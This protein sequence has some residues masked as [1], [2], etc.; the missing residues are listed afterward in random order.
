MLIRADARRLPL[1]DESVQCV[2]TSPPYWGLRDYDVAGQIG[3]E[4]SPDDYV[5]TLVQVFREVRRVLRHDGV[6][7]LNLGDSYAT[8]RGAGLKPKDLVGI[9]WQVAFALRADGWWLRSDVIWSKPNPMP[10][11]IKDRPT[12]AHEYVFLLTKTADYYYDAL[13]IAEPAIAKR[14]RRLVDPTGHRYL[15]ES[16]GLHRAHYSERNARSVWQIV[17]EQ[18]DG[19]HFATFPP[20]L[21]RRCILSGTRFGQR[22][23]DPFVGSGTTVRTA[24]ELGRVGIGCDLSARYLRELASVRQRVTAG[25]F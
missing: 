3:L 14:Q 1:A 13:A 15:D 17:P 22:V 19:A 21:P 11:S 5:A 20:A 7:W 2:V 6:L 10:E 9:P 18:F 12:R 24:R 23:L 8:T 4:A 16:T 25:M